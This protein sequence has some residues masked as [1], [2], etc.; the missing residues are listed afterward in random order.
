V[1][2]DESYDFD[3][4]LRQWLPEVDYTGAN[5]NSGVYVFNPIAN[6]TEN[7][8]YSELRLNESFLHYDNERRIFEFSFG[9]P[10]TNSWQQ[11]GPKDDPLYER[12]KVQV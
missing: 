12:A 10:V 6:M 3:F 8:A 2:N 11:G 9:K 5:N 4:G 7:I 1:E